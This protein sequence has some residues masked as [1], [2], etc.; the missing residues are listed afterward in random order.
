[1]QKQLKRPRDTIELAKLIGDIAIGEILDEEIDIKDE[2]AVSSGRKGGKIEQ[3][4]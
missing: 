1:M 2:K 4:I 3:R